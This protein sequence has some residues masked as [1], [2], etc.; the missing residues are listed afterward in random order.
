MLEKQ[1]YTELN[2]LTK[3]IRIEKWI[4]SESDGY[5]LSQ[6]KKIVLGC[7]EQPAQSSD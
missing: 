1:S 2:R 4:K 5:P 3:R 6:N 7:S